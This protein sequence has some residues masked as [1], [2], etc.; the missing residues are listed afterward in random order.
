MSTMLEQAF[1]DAKALKE[2]AIKNAESVIIEKYSAEIKDAVDSLL[3]EQEEDPFA[4]EDPMAADEPLA[5]APAAPEGDT[6]DVPD[7]P[8]AAA[9]GEKLCPCPEDDDEITIPLDQLAAQIA[10]DEATGELPVSDGAQLPRETAMF[11][12]E[13]PEEIDLFSED[14]QKIIEELAVDVEG[15]KPGWTEAPDPQVAVAHDQELAGQSDDDN[16]DDKADDKK[17][18]L[19]EALQKKETLL[20]EVKLLSSK[21][22]ESSQKLQELTENNKKLREHVY[23]MRDRL[24]ETLVSNAKLLYTNR[25]L[26]SD[27][28]NERQKNKI[29]EAITNT[30]SVEEAKVVYETLQSA[31]GTS[32][33][34]KPKSLSEAVIRDSSSTL[35]RRRLD[36]SKADFAIQRLQ[37]LAGIKKG[38]L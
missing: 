25:V 26:S 36:E 7:M 27:S 14:L 15:V 10:A 22:E 6:E 17:K 31:V 35:P 18:D 37:I 3:S 8:L 12:E 2:A 32:H 19:E 28:L 30:D 16:D 1:I 23:T 9:D 11:E 13:I 38:E 33:M 29:V 20:S 24:A 5:G 4:E 21:N 34:R